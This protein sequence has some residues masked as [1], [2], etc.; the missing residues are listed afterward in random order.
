MKNIMAET[1]RD[2]SESSA[3]MS[4]S[5]RTLAMWP[6]LVATG[7]IAWPIRARFTPGSTIRLA[8]PIATMVRVSS[9]PKPFQDSGAEEIHKETAAI[10]IGSR[11]LMILQS[12]VGLSDLII[13]HVYRIILH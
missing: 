4:M 11:S 5:I 10:K 1:L 13:I 7:T 3:I 2:Y 12:L 8:T 6:M 9:R